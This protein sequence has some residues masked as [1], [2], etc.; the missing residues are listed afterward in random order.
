MYLPNVFYNYKVFC[1]I[2]YY[3][4]NFSFWL[5]A[6]VS[7]AVLAIV[8][9]LYDYCIGYCELIIVLAIGLIIVLNTA[10]ITL[11]TNVLIIV[12][13]DVLIIV[14]IIILPTVLTV[15]RLQI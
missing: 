9:C 3:F 7:N 4:I 13:T 10:L 14:L 12:R 15:N 1:L 5:L 11:L 2:Y 8:Y 6:V